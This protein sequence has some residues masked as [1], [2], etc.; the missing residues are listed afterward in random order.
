MLLNTSVKPHKALSDAACGILCG[1]DQE[2]EWLLPWWWSRYQDHNN[3]PVAFCDFGMSDQARR[4]CE[5]RGSV[6]DIS[7]DPAAVAPRESL[8]VE[9][10]KEWEALYGPSLWKARNS[11]FK[12]P[13]AMIQ[14]PFKKS[15]WID[16][17]CEVLSCVSALFEISTSNSALALVKEP[18]TAHLPSFHPDIKYNSGV[19]VFNQ[20]SELIHQWAE[21]ALELNHQFWGDDPLLSHLIVKNKVKVQEIPE[22]WNWRMNY[23]FSLNAKIYHWVGSGGKNFIREKGGVKPMLDAFFAACST[24]RQETDAQIGNRHG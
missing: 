20:Q 15:I 14:S 8:A 5:Q 24:K 23:G 10:I 19:L 7:F 9:L 2:Q 16:L 11:W 22:V 18:G 21:Q 12:K 13:L 6:I 17:D 1:T 3:F 4:W